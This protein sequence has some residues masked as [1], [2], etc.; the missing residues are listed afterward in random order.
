MSQQPRRRPEIGV[1]AI[2]WKGD[3]FLLIRRGH[4]PR[5]GSWSL[6]GGH[7]ELGE[8]V[9]QAAIREVR[10]ETGV[11]VR[12]LDLLAVVDLIDGDA[13]DPHF[14]Y[15][16][17]DVQAEWLSGDAVAG[18]D[19]EAVAWTS[20]SDLDSFHLSPAMRKVIALAVDKRKTGYNSGALLSLASITESGE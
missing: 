20:P 12:I 2:V 1:G 4:A 17:I 6:P 14:H 9:Q 3:Q 15:T 5:Q 19:A 11:T 10:E 13:A 8:S 18:D 7:Q 16:V